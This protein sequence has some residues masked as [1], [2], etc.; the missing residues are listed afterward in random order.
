M[1]AKTGY[2]VLWFT[3]F[4][5]CINTVMVHTGWKN[6]GH[7][8]FTPK[9]GIS[10]EEAAVS[11]VLAVSDSENNSG[12]PSTEKTDKP[13]NEKAQKGGKHMDLSKVHGGLSKVR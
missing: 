7:F 8:K 4:K 6:P 12:S 1:Q 10:A 2:R 13:S 11:G 9:A 5:A 3:S